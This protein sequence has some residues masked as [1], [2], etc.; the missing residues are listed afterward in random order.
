M[1][2]RELAELVRVYTKAIIRYEQ[3]I[4]S[5]MMKFERKRTNLK[6]DKKLIGEEDDVVNIWSMDFYRFYDGIFL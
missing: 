3:V 6:V 2:Q 1:N 5:Q 4:K